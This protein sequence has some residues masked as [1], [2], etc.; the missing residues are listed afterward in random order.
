[1]SRRDSEL[2]PDDDALASEPELDEA[3]ER[4]LAEALRAAWTPGALDPRR[5]AELLAFAFED[6]FAPPS[7]E[8]ARESERL[9]TALAAGDERDADVR[10]LRALSA[11]N[12]PKAPRREASVAAGA[13]LAGAPRARKSNVL[14]VSFGA[15]TLAAAA[16]FA[17]FF[18]LP[19]QKAAPA[20]ERLAPSRS[21]AELFERE[22][23]QG[24]ATERIDVIASARAHDLRENR[25][26][27]WGAR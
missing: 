7:A 17:L 1:V 22:F 16:A 5:H 15:A 19:A 18:A 4:A 14:F 20:A 2:L 23:E 26:A 8:E 27:M 25:Y 9:R 10:L 6:P 12:E 21:T 3:T 11:A 24:G 13:A